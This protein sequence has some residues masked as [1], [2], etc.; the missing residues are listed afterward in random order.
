VGDVIRKVESD[1][2]VL[3]RT[4]VSHR[5][6]KHASKPGLVTVSGNDYNEMPKGTLHNVLRQA[7]LK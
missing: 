5:H 7:G 1:G 2:W 3:I 4:T 6:F